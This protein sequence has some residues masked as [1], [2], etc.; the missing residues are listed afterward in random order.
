MVLCHWR[1]VASDYSSIKMTKKKKKHSHSNVLADAYIQI[2]VQ[3]VQS[4]GN[5]SA[6]AVDA[7]ALL[8]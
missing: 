1:T 6:G 5:F 2:N 3:I 4:I 8:G 7:N